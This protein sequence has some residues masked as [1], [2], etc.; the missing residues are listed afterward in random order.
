MVKQIVSDEESGFQVGSKEIH[1]PM[2]KIV[3]ENY[4]RQSFFIFSGFLARFLTR[5][6]STRFLARF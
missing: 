3:R 4:L 2:T 1:R 5:L 6:F